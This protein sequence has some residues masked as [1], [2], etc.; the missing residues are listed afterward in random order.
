MSTRPNGEDPASIIPN[1]TSPDQTVQTNYSYGPFPYPGHDIIDNR[2]LTYTIPQYIW[3]DLTPHLFTFGADVV[4]FNN[5]TAS[6]ESLLANGASFYDGLGGNDVVTLP[7]TSN[8]NESVGGGKTLG[9][10]NGAS[11]PFSTDSR[12]GDVYIVSGG[13]G[14]YF[15]DAGA[16]TDEITI[17]GG[18]ASHVS[19]GTGTL[20]ISITGAGSN[21][22][23]GNVTGAVSISGGGTLNLSGSLNGAA[24]IG[25]N[26]I[27]QLG[28]TATGIVVSKTALLKVENGGSPSN[29]E[30]RSGGLEIVSSGGTDLGA[31]DSGN[32]QVFAGGL[33][34]G[35][36]VKSGGLLFVGVSG[37][38]AGGVVS[39]TKVDSGGLEIINSGGTD[40]GATDS[41]NLQVFAGGLASGA[42]VKS[43]GLLFVGLTSF[44]VGGVVSNT[45]IDS[46]GLEIVNSGGTDFGA[47]DSGNLQVFAGGLASGAEVKSGGLL[48]VGLTSFGVGGVVSNTTIDSGGL[49]VVNSGGT[50]LGASV[51][52]RLRVFSSGL[53]SGVEVHSGGTLLG[54]GG[55]VSNTLIDSGGLEVVNS[56]GTDL[57]A[58]VSG[59]LRVFSSGLASGVEVHSGGL[60][61][62][63]V[64]GFGAGGLVSGTTIDSGGFEFINSGGTDL[65]ALIS[66]GKQDVFGYASGV[67][68]LSGGYQYIDSGGTASA[69]IISAG[70][71]L[72]VQTGGTVSGNITFASG[73]S[74]SLQ[75]DGTTLPTNVITGFEPGDIID[76]ANIPYD[77]A[78][79]VSL[80]DS[81]ADQLSVFENG[82]NYQLNFSSGVFPLNTEAT[83]DFSLSSDGRGGTDVTFATN[84][85]HQIPT[86]GGARSPSPGQPS[87][88]NLA[89]LANDSYRSS[90]F[91]ADGFS[92]ADNFLQVPIGTFAGSS[93]AFN[94]EN[95]VF[96]YVN[97]DESEVVIAISGTNFGSTLV[98]IKNLLTDLGSISSGIPTTGLLGSIVAAYTVLAEAHAAYPKAHITLTGHSLGGAIAQLLGQTTNYDTVTFNAPG[99]GLLLSSPLLSNV[100]SKLGIGTLISTIKNTDPNSLGQ[101]DNYH[102]VGDGV[103]LMSPAIGSMYTIQAKNPL[104]PDNSNPVN[105]FFNN[106]VIATTIAQLKQEGTRIATGLQ[107]PNSTLNFLSN[108]VVP[109][110]ESVGGG[111]LVWAAVF[112]PNAI[113]NLFDPTSGSLFQ[114]IESG[115]LNPISS[116]MFLEDSDVSYFEVQAV[117][118]GS[119]GGPVTVSAGASITFGN[120]TTRLEFEAFSSNGQP[121]SLP[122]GYLFDATFA[123]S[124]QVSA[125]LLDLSGNVNFA[126]S[127]SGSYSPQSG[128]TLIVSSG[129]AASGGQV[130]SSSEYVFAGGIAI[131]SVLSDGGV[132]TVWFGGTAVDTIIGSGGRL[133]VFAGGLADPALIYS[134]G[135]EL[136]GTGGVD[137]G[138]QVVGG[139]QDVFGFASG[140]TVLAGLQVVEGGGTA[141]GTIVSSGG[142]LELFAGA[143]A[144]GFTISSGGTL[145]IASGYMLSGYEVGSGVT[146]AVASG[147]TEI[148]AS[149]GTDLGTQIVGG[150]QDVLGFASGTTVLA[151]LQV[152][153]GGGTA[154]GTIVSSGGTLELFAGA[155][156]NGSTIS[157]GGTLEIASGYVLSGY[158]VASGV[159]LEVANGGTA[160][161]VVVDNG[162]LF[163]L[164]GGAVA[165]GY[166]INSGASL[167]I[168]SGY[169]LSNY[170]V[171]SGVALIVASGGT[172]L[173]AQIV[174]G[175]LDVFG[176]GQ[177][178]DGICRFGIV[179]SGGSAIDFTI[180]SGGVLVVSSGGYADPGY[181]QWRYRGNLCGWLRRRHPDLRRNTIRLRHCD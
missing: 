81:S 63:G 85:N 22:V 96:T 32:L 176:L 112:V 101:N 110:F 152:V 21:T 65:G 89:D 84:W 119:I 167:E 15:I 166:S 14:D 20:V 23:E 115:P 39:D 177:R 13:N 122:D 172:D 53:A 102:A 113:A 9:W 44:G 17:S 24:T 46:G 10:A 48:F 31:S 56:G 64:L 90:P 179:E 116:V 170:E 124:T 121:V 111:L 88:Q 55:I 87:L 94:N 104:F 181:S 60:L 71:T 169:V 120:N 164:L 165:S 82:S 99:A 79:G 143:V 51:S 149:G 145:E 57:G 5:L 134:G 70:G 171:A 61:Q 25:A 1:Y 74:G 6:Q 127:G 98:G 148:V 4:D 83:N 95:N 123:S 47:T 16:G 92:P 138:A 142:T 97:S 141:S 178:R 108:Y 146:L 80:L 162:A 156:A 140:T 100:L 68:I 155:V 35:A 27:L 159:T 50:D 118:D 91:G 157:S 54:A 93:N 75:I 52:G 3:V 45:T 12:P 154:S 126:S 175:E 43:G 174:G 173:S 41:G 19:A 137:D 147:G 37:F 107:E 30:I 73:G 40:L 180:L 28:G 160:L 150:E 103:S 139:E 163:E 29:T 128:S 158:E 86:L 72:E 109:A 132:A 26:S 76:L 34:S 106:H 58:S 11:Q 42:E 153:E 2:T 78:G 36:E 114:F 130:S 125:T 151:G 131:S 33:A 136:I 8:Y 59:R 18:G 77:A 67:A 133:E 135:L 144:N 7:N 38:G 69:S 117:I 168:A 49:E 66:G 129:A 62:V 161:G 105:A